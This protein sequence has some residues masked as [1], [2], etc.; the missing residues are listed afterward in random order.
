MTAAVTAALLPLALVYR[1]KRAII[2][3]LEQGGALDIVRWLTR[4]TPRIL[5]FH[6]FGPKD[7]LRVMGADNFERQIAYLKSRF[8]ILPLGELAATRRAGSSAPTNAVAITVDDGYED[9]YQYAFPILKRHAVPATLFVVSRFAA[10][11]LWLWPDLIQY[12]VERSN[13]RELTFDLGS[14]RGHWNLE[15]TEGRFAAWSDIADHCLTLGTAGTRDLTAALLGALG[16]EAPSSP[17]PE[18]RAASW[19]Q[20]REMAAG[21]IEIGSHTRSHP[22]LTLLSQEESREEIEGSKRDIEAQIS[23]PVASFAYPNGREQDFDDRCKREVA[24]AGY[25]LAVAG[26][27]GPDVLRDVFALKRLSIDTDWNDFL[28]AVCGM[29]HLARVLRR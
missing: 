12:A 3:A 11:E 1:A 13:R 20:L 25:S 26:Y 29:K 4:R 5:V 8:R 21:G 28:K 9:F 19:D 22:R 16:V 24:A 10:G 6:R 17:P 15:S 27:Y 7:T 23:R 14:K 2:G 18:L